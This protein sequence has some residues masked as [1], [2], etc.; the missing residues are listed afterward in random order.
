MTIQSVLRAANILSL[1]KTHNPEMGIT[2]IASRVGLNKATAWGLVTTLMEAGLLTQSFDSRKYRLGSLCYDLGMIFTSTLEINRL[3]ME[4]IHRLANQVKIAAR[5]G[6]WDQSTVLI[7]MVAMAH[8]QQSET[9]Q[10]GPRVHAYCTA[11]GKA[12][13]AF[14]DP[15]L[16]NQYLQN[17]PLERL[18]DHTIIDPQ[19]LAYDLELVRKNGYSVGNQEFVLY[20]AGIGAPVFDSTGKIAGAIS[21]HGDVDNI[22]KDNFAELAKAVRNTAAEISSRMGY[23][24]IG[25]KMT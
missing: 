18:T 19:R 22:L 23:S 17:T 16:L 14:L 13:L 24:F 11:I 25:R 3:G 10:I 8:S 21:I 2:E 1:F 15:T 20:G 5:L 12:I 4:P 9:R 7:T 6:I